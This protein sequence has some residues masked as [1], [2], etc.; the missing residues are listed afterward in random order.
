MID[1]VIGHPILFLSA[2]NELDAPMERRRLDGVRRFVRASGLRV[3]VRA[4]P[5]VNAGKLPAILAHFRPSGC[6]AE[7]GGIGEPIPPERFGDVPV[8]YFEAPDGAGWRDVVS[9]VADDVAVA[10]MAFR[11]LAMAHPP[12]FAAVP[13]NCRVGWSERRMKAFRAIC[14]ETGAKCLVFRNHPR[15]GDDAR[16]ARLAKWA[17]ALPLHAAVFAVN[18]PTAWEV[19]RAFAAV[20]RALPRTA[21]LVGVDAIGPRRDFQSTDISSIQLDFEVAGYLAA[22][23]L[24]ERIAAQGGRAGRRAVHPPARLG[25]PFSP[26]LVDR[27]R[28]TGGRGRRENW[29]MD[30]VDIIRREACDG[31]SAAGIAARFRCSR[32]LFDIRFKEALGH[33]AQDE[34]EH[35]RLEKAFELLRNGAPIGAIAAL[36]GYRSDTTLR[37]VFLHRTG[38]SMREWR[39]R[40]RF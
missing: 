33:T 40:N 31:L 19:E 36:C 5:L 2:N 11:E 4:V 24:V 15:E 10:R 3:A 12:V 20:G 21:T 13:W 22:R 26:L 9:V 8:V 37:W 38:M 34:I 18:D 28:S 32:R 35:V 30:A 1:A 25:I 27:R 17:A 39:T 29:I 16:T 23:A 7:C 14:A 6:V